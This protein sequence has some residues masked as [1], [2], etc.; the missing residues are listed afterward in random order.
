MERNKKEYDEETKGYP[1]VDLQTMHG[2]LKQMCVVLEES[3]FKGNKTRLSKIKFHYVLFFV[4]SD[5]RRIGQPC[6]H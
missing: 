6:L 3:H 4:I 5:Y 2:R 1:F